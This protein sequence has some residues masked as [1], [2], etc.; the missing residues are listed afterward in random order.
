MKRQ[1]TILAV[2]AVC[3]LALG[4]NATL[5]TFTTPTGATES[6][7]NPVD[8]SAIFATSTD[9]VTITLNNLLANPK[10]VAQLIS[11][12]SFG[13]SSGQTAGTLASSSGTPRFVAGDGT[14]TPG[15]TG[16]TGWGVDAGTLHLTALGFVGPAGLIL[17]PPDVSG[18][19]ANANNSIA[20]N[21]PHNPFLGLSATFVL[22]VPGVDADTTINDV[23]FSFGTTPGNYVPS[24]PPGVPDGG[25]TL[26]L[27]GVALS[28]LGLLRRKLS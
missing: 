1:L 17:G 22:N 10:T 25:T 2:M 19:Y 8:A 4:A 7:G 9:T 13:L 28:G 24:T 11:D 27:L 5:M 21:G 26:A 23:Q 16:S 12:I 14:W 3:L 15:A 6:G 18:V 20:G